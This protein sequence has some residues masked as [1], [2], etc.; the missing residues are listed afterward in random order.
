MY[1]LD[2]RVSPTGL[3]AGQSSYSTL[4]LASGSSFVEEILVNSSF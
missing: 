1:Y 4:A 2:D 3:V